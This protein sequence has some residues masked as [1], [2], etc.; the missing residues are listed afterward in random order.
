MGKVFATRDLSCSYCFPMWVCSWNLY[1]PHCIVFVVRF[2][3]DEAAVIGLSTIKEF[4][5]DFK[6]VTTAFLVNIVTLAWI[7][8]K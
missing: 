4:A 8:M 7:H 6:E 2:P 5:N 3:S 1:V